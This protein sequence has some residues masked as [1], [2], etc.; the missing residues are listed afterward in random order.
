MPRFGNNKPFRVVITEEDRLNL[1]RLAESKGVPYG[2]FF[3]SSGAAWFEPVNPN[4]Q[5]HYIYRTDEIEPLPLDIRA[6]KEGKKH[7]RKT[8]KDNQ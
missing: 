1:L 5:Y 2:V 6:T 4:A 7:A 3:T 8:R